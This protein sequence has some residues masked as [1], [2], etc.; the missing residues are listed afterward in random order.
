MFCLILIESPSCSV[1][2]MSEEDSFIY[3]KCMDLA[4]VWGFFPLYS[5]SVWQGLLHNY[6]GRYV[7]KKSWR[8][9]P[10][11]LKPLKLEKLLIG[12]LSFLFSQV[13]DCFYSKSCH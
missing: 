3:E 6:L 8:K 5:S 1:E 13:A 9:E 12:A 11:N 2:G 7:H 4:H 10:T